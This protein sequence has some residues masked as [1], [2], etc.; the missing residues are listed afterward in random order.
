M[1]YGDAT[2]REYERL[3]DD[4]FGRE[5]TID[6]ENCIYCDAEVEDFELIDE[7]VVCYECKKYNDEHK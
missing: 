7:E 1:N 6:F 4:F 5:E 2:Q 3:E